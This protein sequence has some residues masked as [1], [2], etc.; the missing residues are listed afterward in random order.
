M[1]TLLFY[2]LTVFSLAGCSTT[3]SITDARAKI[4]SHKTIAILPFEVRFDLR[5]SNQ[6]QFSEK[7][8]AEV[9]HMMAT[10]LQEHLYRWLIKYS[11]TKPYTVHIQDVEI[12]DSIL[13]DKKISYFVLYNMPRTELARMFDVDAI[14]TPNV[15]FAQPNSEAAAV[16]LSAAP[17][18]NLL[19]NNLPTQE[20]K[21]Q[22]FLTDRESETAFWTLET[23]TQNSHFTKQDSNKEKKKENI[24]FPLFENIDKTMMKFIKKFPYLKN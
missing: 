11:Y 17:G 21:M 12:T 1:K 20:M 6:K 22:I 5:K 4:K 16:A 13:S 7:E 19:F 3:N 24:L 10:D 8:M 2:C 9:R 23:K 14:L 15:I 18:Q